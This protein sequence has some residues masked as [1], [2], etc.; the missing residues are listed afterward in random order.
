MR[1]SY[2]ITILPGDGIGPEIV[3]ATLEVLEALQERS[4]KFS[5]IYDFHPAGAE[6][7]RE[8]G[9][10]I[11]ADALEA[12]KRA[13][14]TLKGPVGLPDVRRPDGT[15]AGLLGGILRIGFDLYANV[16][17]IRLFPNVAT[18]LARHD[19]DSID[20]VILR[21]SSEGLYLSRG[22]GL[23]T[24][25]AATDSLLMTRRGCERIVRFAFRLAMDKKRGAPEDGR[26]RVTLVEKSNVLKSF[27]FFRKIFNTVAEEF[28]DSEHECLYVDAAAAALVNRPSHFQVIVTE[29]MFGDILSDLGGATVGG[30]G[31]CP[32]ANIGDE[33]A[34]FEPIHGSAPDIAGRQRAN[35][36]SQILAG[37]MMLRYL[38]ELQ[39]AAQLEAAVWRLYAERRVT[40]LP[41]GAIEGGS[42][43]FVN[44][45]KDI[46]K[47]PKNS[48]SPG[49]A[50]F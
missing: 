50:A 29:N 23:T 34:Y 9:A 14:A 39:A 48:P 3:D 2:W 27:V 42:S 26:R 30:L 8:T 7:Y 19:P 16:R 24:R 22:V 11:S 37:A 1:K 44:A 18:P 46:L 28:P 49:D 6:C 21:E 45:L 33:Q 4:G 35:P 41:G 10:T 13:N 36:T 32:S 25:D 17:P 5:L 15:E 43:A 47:T 31:M 40:L 12:F 38:G 20:Y